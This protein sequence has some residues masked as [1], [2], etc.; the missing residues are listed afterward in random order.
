M[1]EEEL[2]QDF[3]EMAVKKKKTMVLIVEDLIRR[4]I[5]FVRNKE[6]IE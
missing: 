1:I 2:H 6:D 5:E 3:K 4:W